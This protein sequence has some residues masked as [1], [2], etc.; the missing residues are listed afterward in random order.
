MGHSTETILA[1]VL[2]KAQQSGPEA[3]AAELAILGVRLPDAKP[4][5]QGFSGVKR[6]KPGT[7]KQFN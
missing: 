7:A 1:R 3:A 5:F 4:A 2:A 6:G